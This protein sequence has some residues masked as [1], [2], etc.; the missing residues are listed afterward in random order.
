MASQVLSECA[1]IVG[2]ATTPLEADTAL[3]RLAERYTARTIAEQ[4]RGR[5]SG[6]PGRALHAS[7]VLDFK[8]AVVA[9][10]ALAYELHRDHALVSL[11][12]LGL[13][14]WSPDME[15]EAEAEFGRMMDDF[16]LAMDRLR[17]P[18]EGEGSPS[19]DSTLPA[20]SPVA[21]N[22]RGYTPVR[23]T[24]RGKPRHS[25][26]AAL[27]V[28]HFEEAVTRLSRG[29]AIEEV[30]GAYEQ[31]ARHSIGRDT[32]YAYLKNPDLARD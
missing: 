19:P 6:D 3:E 12:A 15:V 31:E 27:I 28:A 24:A 4:K 2:S 20:E 25:H 9:R 5:P 1:G 16:A 8:R 18:S 13:P 10:F 11:D 14:P 30:Q 23:F 26:N 21:V 17:E 29:K 22:G 32:V 7:G